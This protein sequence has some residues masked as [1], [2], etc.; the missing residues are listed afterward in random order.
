[1]AFLFAGLLVMT[2]KKYSLFVAV[3]MCV[4]HYGLPLFKLLKIYFVLLVCCIGY[5][6]GLH[7]CLEMERR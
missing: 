2:A 4:K 7:L 3:A 1:M 5:M 6:F